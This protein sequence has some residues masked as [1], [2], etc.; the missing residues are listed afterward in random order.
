MERIEDARRELAEVGSPSEGEG[1]AEGQG[2]GSGQGRSTEDGSNEQQTE[3]EGI[4]QEIGGRLMQAGGMMK[5][6]T[7]TKLGQ[8]MQAPE[9]STDAMD[10]G[11]GNV[12]DYLDTAKRLVQR[13]IN[14][15]QISRK[16][17]VIKQ[18]SQA[19]EKYKSLV[20]EYFKELAEEEEQ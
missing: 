6:E 19:P 12:E 13:L 17:R 1:K 11:N 15:N 9:G 20:E 14:E 7:L 2:N 5:N 3:L 10:A 18:S 16:S 4:L 8:D